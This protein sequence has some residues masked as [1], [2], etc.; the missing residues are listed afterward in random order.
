MSTTRKT[1]AV[2]LILNKF[3]ECQEAVSVVA[4]AEELHEE[5][6][7]T[8]VY[9]IL[10]R[11]E[12]DGTLHS[13]TGSDGRRWYAKGRQEFSGDHLKAHPHFQCKTCGKVE[14][15][16]FDFV[17]PSLPHH[18]IDTAELFLVGKCQACL[19]EDDQ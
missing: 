2:K 16:S 5:M 11:L 17:I 7:R 15:L 19:L 10:E 13:F 6:N 4:L 1:R 8:T 14:C 12:V 9:R 18:R 3:T